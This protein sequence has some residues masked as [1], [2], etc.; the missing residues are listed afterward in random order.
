MIVKVNEIFGTSC[1]SA[2]DGEKLY[3]LIKSFFDKNE[4]IIIDFSEVRFFASPFFNFSLGKIHSQYD[5]KT[6]ENLLS[7]RIENSVGNLIV[8]KVIENSERFKNTKNQTLD[9]L[10]DE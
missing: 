7:I 6:I 3:D 8:S 4:K 1:I 9:D 10:F 5:S 2:E